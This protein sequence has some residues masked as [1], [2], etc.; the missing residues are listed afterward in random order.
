[1]LNGLDLQSIKLDDDEEEEEEEEEYMCTHLKW[2]SSLLSYKPDVY[3]LA[4]YICCTSPR[5]QCEQRLYEEVPD[6]S[7]TK[8]LPNVKM[9]FGTS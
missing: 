8:Q 9:R 6:P 7:Q 2:S 1:M 4:V 5:L 3:M